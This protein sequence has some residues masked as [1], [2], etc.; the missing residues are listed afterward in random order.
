ME[1]F[2]LNYKGA[3]AVIAYKIIIFIWNILFLLYANTV[4]PTFAKL[5][6]YAILFETG[7][8]CNNIFGTYIQIY[9]L[10]WA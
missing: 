4:K 7:C 9:I 6:S 2:L 10:V 1:S 3:L 5:T 8:S